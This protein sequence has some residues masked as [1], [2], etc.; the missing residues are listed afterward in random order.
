MKWKEWSE[1]ARNKAIWQN[2]EEK[3][4]LKAEYVRDY[5]LRLWFEEDLDEIISILVTTLERRQ[6]RSKN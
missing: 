1:L 3:G 4:L 5:V 6:K 2:R